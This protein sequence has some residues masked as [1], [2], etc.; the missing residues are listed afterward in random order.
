MDVRHQ[1]ATGTRRRIRYSTAVASAAES[2]AQTGE[3]A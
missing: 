2:S 3:G 1:M